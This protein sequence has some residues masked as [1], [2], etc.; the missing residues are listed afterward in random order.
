MEPKHTG[1]LPNKAEDLR[2]RKFVC[3]RGVEIQECARQTEI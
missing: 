1:A 3:S 2:V